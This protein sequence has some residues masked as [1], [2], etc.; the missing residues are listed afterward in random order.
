M[1]ILFVTRIFGKNYPHVL[2]VTAAIVH[3]RNDE[4]DFLI[5]THLLLFICHGVF[6][7]KP[8]HEY[9]LLADW[10]FAFA[11]SQLS[12]FGENLFCADISYLP[13]PL[14]FWLIS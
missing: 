6:L 2:A 5:I 13:L 1:S 12:F 3:R 14:S 11:F 9:L 10:L 4:R 7:L 8:G